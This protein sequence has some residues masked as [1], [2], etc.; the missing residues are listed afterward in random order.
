MR[1]RARVY[2]CACVRARAC[3]HALRMVF[4]H[5]IPSNSYAK[6]ATTV[7]LT[8]NI[9]RGQSSSDKCTQNCPE[10]G[11]G[12]TTRNCTDVWAER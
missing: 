7:P 8:P 5:N 4:A 2:V 9:M 10:T 1:A 11:T 6:Q 12:Q 3:M